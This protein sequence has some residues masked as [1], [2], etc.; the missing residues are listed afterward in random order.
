M[1]RQ[2]MN[3]PD[4]E[5]RAEEIIAAAEAAGPSDQAVKD[6]SD[7]DAQVSR[8]VA[9]RWARLS[10]ERRRALVRAMITRDEEDL[11]SDYER[12]LTIG[13]ADSDR[14]VRTMAASGLAEQR[15]SATVQALLDVAQ[16][17]EVANVR[18]QAI[19]ALDS[20]A[21]RATSEQL[22]PEVADAIQD[23]LTRIAHGDPSR[24]ARQV[25][26]A[27]VGY[28]DSQPDTD[29][30]IESAY[31]SDDEDE[32]IHALRAMGRMGVSRWRAQV[33]QA[34]TSQDEDLRVEAVRAIACS[35][36]QGFAATMVQ[37]A[38]EDDAVRDDAIHALGEI[39]GET[40]TRALRDLAKNPDPAIAEQAEA[41]LDAATLMDSVG[42][43]RRS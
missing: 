3:N 5:R 18:V 25:A 35:G 41:A 23:A 26:L 10:V 29:A 39:G 38:Y 11:T 19:E 40:A 34:V 31:D 24:H 30:L 20:A 28:F 17:D 36:D 8:H 15:L 16:H 12:A 33:E 4:A 14:E 37:L 13:L 42:P 7:L 9:R 32:M 21:E 6:F 2:R 22:P 27:A 1:L 43:A